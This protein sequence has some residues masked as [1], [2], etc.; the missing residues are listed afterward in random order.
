MHTRRGVWHWDF[1]GGSTSASTALLLYELDTSLTDLAAQIG[2]EDAAACYRAC[3]DSLTYIA[4]TASR[5]G[6]SSDHV[7][8]NSYYL[9]VA[10]HQVA[11]IEEEC[12]LR[13]KHGL[14]VELLRRE[15]IEER[16]TFSAPA[17]LWSKDAA[18]ID[19][20][21]FV[22]ALRPRE[23]IHQRCQ[24]LKLRMRIPRTAQ[25]LDEL[26]VA[27]LLAALWGLR[28]AAVE[29][30]A[31]V[32]ALVAGLGISCSDSNHAD[33]RPESADT[34]AGGSASS[35]A[36]EE[37]DRDEAVVTAYEEASQARAEAL[38]PPID[39]R[40]FAAFL[41]EELKFSHA[42]VQFGGRIDRESPWVATITTDGRVVYQHAGG[43]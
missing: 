28:Q 27:G 19:A 37:S 7:P 17:A 38:A 12:S 3:L 35:A 42:T 31:A 24:A 9:A 4:E 23:R 33:D 13:R 39:Q 43:S 14:N 8:R 5:L 11:P 16:F 32:V 22:N 41:Y 15:D 25:R 30:D 34:T 6:L 36:D 40:S 10:P 18:E 1:G 26:V 21:A 20:V 29:R 2:E